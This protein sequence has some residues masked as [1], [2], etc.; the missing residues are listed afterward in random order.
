MQIDR[1]DARDGK[2]CLGQ[3][4]EGDDDKEVGCE[5]GEFGMQLRVIDGVGLDN[6]NVQ[7][8]FTRAL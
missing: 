1:A 2:Q 7:R 4:G 8:F 5:R 6:G 3:N